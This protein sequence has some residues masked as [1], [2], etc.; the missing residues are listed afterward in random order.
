MAALNGLEKTR[1]NS[2]GDLLDLYWREIKDNEPMNRREEMEIFSRVR[3]GDQD[4][5]EALVKANLRFV[6]SVA[7]EYCQEDGPLMMDLI[8][9]GNMGLMRAIKTF[10]ETRGFKFITYAVWW[11]RQA[12][13]KSLHAQ[14]KATRLPASHINDLQLV[15]KETAA[16]SQELGRHPTFEEIAERVELGLERLHNAL[17]AG[18]G[19]LSLDAPVFEDEDTS[20]MAMF[21]A[22]EEGTDGVE[23][24]ALMQTLQESLEVLSEREFVIIQ[25]YFG[26]NGAEA[27]TLEQI[28][29]ELG[30]TRE[31][32]RQLRNR[33]LEKMR[34]QYGD[35]LL[36]LSAN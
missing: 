24:E 22:E 19:D 34:A 2:H 36:E 18:V 31:R 14:H 9:E 16:L 29:Q 4:A 1:I 15:E 28:G 13:R 12:M 20:V 17:E 25:S 7:R 21:A 23:E 32:V 30:V 33:A 6:V 3:A 35:L 10:D 26:L 11:I 27:M 8:A 5:V